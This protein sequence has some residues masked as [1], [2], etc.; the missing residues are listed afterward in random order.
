M[1]KFKSI[2]NMEMIASESKSLVMYVRCRLG[3]E[4]RKYEINDRSNRQLQLAS[5]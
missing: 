3:Y 1:S 4:V 5:F 2:L